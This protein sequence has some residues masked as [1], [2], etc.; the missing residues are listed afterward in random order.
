VLLVIDTNVL[1]SG[2]LWH[3]PPHALLDKVRDGVADLVL[4]PAL[5]AE[6][7]AA[8]LPG[9]GRRCRI[10]LRLGGSSRSHCVRRRRLTYPRHVQEHPDRRCG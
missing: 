10:G 9:P 8:Y 2:L 7:A 3:G 6:L 4:S 5:I 1:L